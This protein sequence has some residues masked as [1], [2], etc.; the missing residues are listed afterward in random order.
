MNRFLS[1]KKTEILP[2]IMTLI[3]LNIFGTAVIYLMD[4]YLM[5][6]LVKV[7]LILCNI[8]YIYH[9]GVWFTVKYV[10]DGNQIVISA[11]GGL[12]KVIIKSED[13]KSFVTRQGKIKGIGLSGISS[14]RFAIGRIAVKD[15]GTTRM[16]VTDNENIIYLKT[17]AMNYG[18]SPK[19]C[20]GFK[21]TLL[22]LG[23]DNKEW[24]KG[25]NKVHGMYKEAKFMVPMVITSVILLVITFLPI[26]LYVLNKLPD[27]MPLAI[28]STMSVAKVGTDKQFA[29]SQMLYGVLNMA[30]FFC[31]YY[32]AHFCA[33]YD[34][35]AAYRY[36]YI[37][38]LVA[39]VFL[40]LQI[41]LITMKI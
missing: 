11:W 15:L 24:E 32:A 27:I 34:K 20:E 16:F 19:D 8:F 31:M 36:I 14:N 5:L 1:D 25:Y 35:K 7:I 29:F 6:S 30:I 28:N 22:S 17:E 41:V 33:K 23:I 18:I 2:T 3:M 12:K 40:Y 13:I 21:N 39:I 4:S 37:S 9:I 10:V 26:I 38:L